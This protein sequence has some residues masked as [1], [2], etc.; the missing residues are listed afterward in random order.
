MIVTTYSPVIVVFVATVGRMCG[1]QGTG[2][3]VLF[4][5]VLAA[6]VIAHFVHLHRGSSHG[7]HS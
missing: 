6:A 7:H 3:T 1:C 4:T 5:M 2:F